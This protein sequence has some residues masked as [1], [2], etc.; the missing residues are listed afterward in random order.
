MAEKIAE[1]K[2]VLPFLRQEREDIRKM[3]LQGLAGYLQIPEVLDWFIENGQ[4]AVQLVTEMLQPAAKGYLSDILLILINLSDKGACS[5]HM[6]EVRVIPR[7]MLLLEKGAL[8]SEMQELCL[9]LINNL[10]S[11]SVDAVD[12]ILQA[13]HKTLEGYYLSQLI[14]RFVDEHMD[15]SELIIQPTES[16]GA[17]GG[18][19]DRSKWVGSILGNCAQCDVGRKQLI[20]DPDSLARYTKL[21]STQDPQLRLAVTCLVKNLLHDPDLHTQIIEAGSPDVLVSRLDEGKEK[22]DEILEV[23]V[24]SIRCLTLSEPGIAFCD[25]SN[26]K[27]ILTR[28]SEDWKANSPMKLD[29][30]K[31]ISS[32]DDVQ[33]V[34]V[35]EEDDTK[36]VTRDGKKIKQ[37]PIPTESGVEEI[38]SDVEDIEVPQMPQD[39]A[40]KAAE[41][42]MDSIE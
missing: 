24:A 16:D 31:I 2:E 40:T 13:G 4:E 26:V 36:T 15:K 28:I 19:R 30:E 12:A 9:I 14:R 41:T 17:V 18:G 7:T 25:G 21:L 33:D 23:V 27:V 8:S 29:A 6:L 38:D 32:L 37:A 20:D 39:E 3:A 42:N 11:V 22:Q 5:R 1:L 35:V 34:H 10:T